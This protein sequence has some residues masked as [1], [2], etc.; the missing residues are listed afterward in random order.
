LRVVGLV[1]VFCI[2]VAEVFNPWDVWHIQNDERSKWAGEVVLFLAPWVMP[3]FM[4]VAGASAAHSLARR[5]N[6]QFINE[7]VRRV[8]VPFILALLILV[9]PQV[10]LERLAKGQFQGSFFA[11]Y[12]H[13]F[14][15]IYPSGNFSWHHL[16]FLAFLF[17]FAVITLPL[18]RWL[19]GG[20]GAGFLS[21]IASGIQSP[22]AVFLLGLPWMA[23]RL[24]LWGALPESHTVVGGFSNHALL[25]PAYV[26]GF[27][28]VVEPRIERA[29]VGQWRV[30]IAP[31]LTLSAAFFVF[32]WPEDVLV[33]LPVPFSPAYV[34][35]W[36]LY[37]FGTWCWLIVALGMAS[38]FRS[39]RT[40]FLVHA[41]RLVYPFYLLHHLVI[42][43][44]AYVVVSWTAALH[45]KVV[46][47]GASA[48]V[49]T[50]ALCEL[51]AWRPARVNR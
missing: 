21:R 2:H 29:I 11:F 25:L 44:A 41:R 47:V 26:Y 35:L 45:V 7:R 8:L 40:G 34:A 4:L 1:A 3:M 19:Q 48:L 12:P 49:I 43:A 33:R 10:Y 20:A 31:A 38:A 17:A 51:I 5:S 16:W 50:V 23:W 24:M 28:L 18:F 27:V 14:D 6:R 36:M 9:P 39:A 37:T 13:F 42:V 46:A 32:V 30:A 15:G 22:G